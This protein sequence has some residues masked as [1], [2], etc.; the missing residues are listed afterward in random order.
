MLK[1]RELVETRAGRRKQ[2]RVTPLSD[3]LASC[4]G[5]LEV[6]GPL[7]GQRGGQSPLQSFSRLP[8]RQ[9]GATSLCQG[10]NQQREILSLS[11]FGLPPAIN[12]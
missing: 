1:A 3:A 4:N 5:F 8:V 10:G 11:P 2:H 7:G 12:T 9:H 6:R